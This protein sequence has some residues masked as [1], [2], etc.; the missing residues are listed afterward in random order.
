MASLLGL[1]IPDLMGHRRPG[2]NPVLITR[3]STVVLSLRGVDVIV[4]K[5]F[6]KCGDMKTAYMRLTIFSAA[7]RQ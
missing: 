5:R 4:P 3:L 2:P 7:P 6:R 1:C